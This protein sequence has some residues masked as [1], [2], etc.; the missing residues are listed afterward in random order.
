MNWRVVLVLICFLAFSGL[1]I[2]KLYSLQILKNDFYL[3]LSRG[4]DRSGQ[5]RLG[6]RGKILAQDGEDLTPLALNMESSFC[7]AVPTRIP[8]QKKEKIVRTLADILNLKEKAQSQLIKDFENKTFVKIKTDLSQSELTQLQKQSL[9]GIYLGQQT[10]RFYPKGSLAS[11][12]L[13]FL[14][15]EG[16][17]QY[18]LESAYHSILQGQEGFD[19]RD[20]SGQDLILTLD[21]NLQFKAEQLLKQAQ[22][23]FSFKEGQLI[24]MDPRNGAIL[25]LTEVPNFDPN[26]YSE[27]S[28]QM[29]IFKTKS[30][31]NLFEPG[32]AFK[33]ITMAGA[34]NENAVTPKTTYVDTGKAEVPGGTIYNYEKK[35]W[36]KRTM[37]EVLE[38]SIN[39]GAV[40]AERELGH[41]NFLDYIQRFG[42][43]DQTGI[44]LPGEVASENQELK[45]GYEMNF[46]TASFG[47]GIEMTPIQLAQAFAIIANQGRTVQP[48]LRKQSSLTEDF[49]S[50]KVIS[51][52]SSSQLTEMLVSVVEEGFGKGAKIPGYFIAGKTGTA[53][54][55]LEEGSGYYEHRTIQ[56]FVGFFPAFKPQFLILVKLDN[57]QTKSAGYSA[58][59]VFQQLARYVIDYYQVPPDY[60]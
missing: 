10:K 31:Q 3:A 2:Y 33:P 58:V 41:R 60:E 45:K 26:R 42:I 4:Q 12:L 35:V 30:V 29:E 55:P 15:P 53:Q 46:A 40:F 14:G 16:R 28:D 7:Y 23:Q 50:E 39:T 56:T 21:Y 19:F 24:V 8:Q 22:E 48:H 43:L 6:P 38:K 57:P 9:P 59:P 25:A 54:V 32:S 20:A 44:D 1:I 13:G 27:W 52:K 36:G 34:L 17:G 5:I 49:I 18:G 37:T 11:H 51:K 47:Q